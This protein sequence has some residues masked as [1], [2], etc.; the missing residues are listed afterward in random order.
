MR[1]DRRYSALALAGILALASLTQA[2]GQQICRPKLNLQNVHFSQMQ[3]KTLRRK[4]SAVVAVDAS[5]C[6]ANATGSFE[7]GYT[8]LQEVGPDADFRQRFTWRVPSVRVQLDF[9][10]TEA[11]QRYWIENVSA[12][13]CAQN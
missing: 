9:A 8:R 5:G 3:P 1:W 13:E 12:C 10:G 7:L 4:W 6:A 2:Q 11:V